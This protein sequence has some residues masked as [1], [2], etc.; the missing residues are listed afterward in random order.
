M[1]EAP[2]ILD[3]TAPPD[4]GADPR[5]SVS[6]VAR[7]NDLGTPFAFLLSPMSR[8]VAGNNLVADGGCTPW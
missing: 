4:C 5:A 3:P 2:P 6:H 1:S 8:F 7:V